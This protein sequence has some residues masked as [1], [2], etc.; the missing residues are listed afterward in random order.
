MADPREEIAKL[1][2]LYAN[3]PEGRVFT[4]LAEAYRKSGELE[5]AREILDDGLRRH[6]DYSSAHVVLGRVLADMGQTDGAT[7]AFRR[8]LELDRHNLVALQSL[9]EIATVTG[10][11]QEALH[12]YRELLS[13]DPSDERL[14]GTVRDL[15]ERRDAELSAPPAEPVEESADTGAGAILSGAPAAER[16]E[17][18]EAIEPP[19]AAV[20]WSPEPVAPPRGFEWSASEAVGS[21]GET[22]DLAAAGPEPIDVPGLE[23]GWPALEASSA[24]E[25]E[26]IEAVRP[27]DWEEAVG[28]ELEPLPGDLGALTGEAGDRAAAEDPGLEPILGDLGGLTG[29]EVAEDDLG[30]ARQWAAAT[31]WVED[32]AAFDFTAGDVAFEETPVTTDA[33]G[34]DEGTGGFDLT[35][36]T[37]QE[38]AWP[39]DLTEPTGTPEDA[40]AELRAP[41]APPAW[42]EAT[43]RGAAE[44]GELVTE[45]MAELYFSQGFYGRAVDVYRSL[46]DERPE[47][48][49]LADRLREAEAALDDGSSAADPGDSPPEPGDVWLEGIASVWTGAGGVAGGETTPYAWAEAGADEEPAGPPTG[50]FLR[51]LLSWRPSTEW[52]APAPAAGAADPGDVAWAAAEPE[53]P[54]AYDD[55]DVPELELH[56]DMEAPDDGEPAARWGDEPAMALELPDAAS[57]AGADDDVSDDDEDLE[58]FR[59]WLQ[60]LKK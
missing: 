22:D 6:S 19:E 21:P 42:A 28:I 20:S 14:R 43:A 5:R 12:Y 31:E 8:V 16:V 13:V 15:E 37:A 25:A 24:G 40:T 27:E 29:D 18:E 57:I 9:G 39:A 59:S 35:P 3:N 32:T 56:A 4:H 53:A 36:E 51:S 1:E 47:D 58:M 38:Q 30:P 55:S 33:F 10:R 48:A 17:A 54:T 50:D 11:T 7:A 52:A 26:P 60:S 2:S 45:T 49:R 44:G 23:T 46:L 34:L 41:E